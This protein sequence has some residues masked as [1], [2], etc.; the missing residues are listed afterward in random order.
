MCA[1]IARVIVAIGYEV[2]LVVA[3]MV[4]ATIF[5]FINLTPHFER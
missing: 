5:S 1:V 4:V 3:A 2:L